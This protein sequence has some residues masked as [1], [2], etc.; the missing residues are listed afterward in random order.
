VLIVFG[1]LPKSS[2][3]KVPLLSSALSKI[4]AEK[5]KGMNNVALMEMTLL[6]ALLTLLVT[7]T[8][9]NHPTLSISTVNH[10]HTILLPLLPP[11]TTALE[12]SAM[13]NV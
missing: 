9:Q 10:I 6:L 7:C 13:I 11:T 4:S 3:Q 8:I 2:F 5:L 1:P 12:F